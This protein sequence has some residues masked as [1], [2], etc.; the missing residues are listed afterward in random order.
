M[1]YDNYEKKILKVA[2]VLSKIVRL[3][4]LIIT[5]LCV[6]LAAVA[7]LLIAKGTVVKMSVPD[8][9]TYGEIPSV[10]ATAFLSDTRFEYRSAS[11]S[12]WTEEVPKI[13]G[14]Y[15]V[16]AF[17]EG[18]FNSIKYSD[19]KKITVA[20]RSVDVWVSSKSVVYGENPSVSTDLAFS[21]RVECD[22]FTYDNILLESTAVRP[23]AAF[24]RFFDENGNDVSTCYKVNIVPK[25]IIISQRGITVTVEDSKKIY[26][27]IRFS[28][29]KYELTGGTLA[30]KDKLVATFELS[31]I[32]VGSE[33]NK[34]TLK[35][36]NASGIDVTHHYKIEEQF[37]KLEIDKRELLVYT[38]E[39]TVVYDGQRVECKGFKIESG[40]YPLVGGH[41]LVV[42]TTP[43]IVNAGSYQNLLTF[44]V[45]DA[46]GNDQTH[47]YNIIVGTG[48]IEVQKRP[49][50]ITTESES[51]MYDGENHVFR[52]YTVN[53]LAQGHYVL[54][55]V[56]SQITDVG[57]IENKFTPKIYRDGQN[58]E[59]T[60]NYDI[61]FEC[62]TLEI[63]KRPV[64][65]ESGSEN[66]IYNGEAQE[67]KWYGVLSGIDFAKGD[68][69]IIKK[70]TALTDV[71]SAQNVILEYSV[72]GKNGE[73]KTS[74][75]ELSFR[76]G[77]ITIVQRPITVMP[78]YASKIYDDTPLKAEKITVLEEYG[79]PLVSGH[80]LTADVTGSRIDAGISA[81]GLKNV[82]VWSGN[83]D[84]TH[85]YRVT[86]EN[87]IIEI[88]P[89]PI[90]VETL[91]ANKYYD[92][93]ALTMH[94]CNVKN[95]VEGHA[96]SVTYTDHIR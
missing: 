8:K 91:S 10:E 26:D 43:D 23:D 45:L 4:P 52:E 29:D 77:T 42:D 41:K 49:L 35:I 81:S 1:L 46:G 83:N 68:S 12:T 31:M 57:T 60:Q 5:V 66:L 55:P 21:D 96:L 18:A 47:N 11:K 54:D 30:D 19:E 94:S 59:I 64:T 15:Y 71:G 40:E 50:T 17:A 25:D 7:G 28:Y 95:L 88:F 27:G 73:D 13:P 33:I 92:G 84:V 16:R 62:G 93:T 72:L 34:P 48:T 86:V 89:R 6:I 37:G 3:L 63:T 32:D 44:K 67:I 20:P 36:V 90:T 22:S 76:N 53:N 82:R 24:V 87:N 85:N 51:W 79:L 65:V 14:D 56:W 75:Y 69:F 74:N 78:E 9:I 58:T 39:C 2:N 61:T 80:S 70:A 38:D